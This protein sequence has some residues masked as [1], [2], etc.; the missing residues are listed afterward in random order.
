MRA[1]RTAILLLLATPALGEDVVPF[2]PGTLQFF[3]TKASFAVPAPDGGVWVATKT[4]ITRYTAAGA[5]VTYAINPWNSAPRE[6]AL[7]ADGSIWFST[8]Y[9]IG[10]MSA[11]GVVVEQHSIDDAH[12]L[13]VAADGALWFKRTPGDGIHRLSGGV[14]KDFAEPAHAWSSAPASGSDMWML[15]TGFSG[16]PRSLFRVTA[17]GGVTEFPLSRK[18]LY[19]ELRALPDGTLYASMGVYGSEILHIAPN[20]Q[21]LGRIRT[22]TYHPFGLFVADSEGNIWTGGTGV[23][24]YL[25]RSG[26]IAIVEMPSDPRTCE[27]KLFDNYIPLAVD[28]DGGVWIQVREDTLNQTPGFPVPPCDQP[29]PPP[30]PDLIRVDAQQV[31]AANPP[32]RRRSR[33]SRP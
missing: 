25:D 29:A 15:G 22:A 28:S 32:H 10:R 20:G 7:A 5:G 21:I 2:P 13:T 31:L 27:N 12:H 18:F 24:G 4:G 17:T 23:L 3:D 16:T 11:S 6:L 9:H 26:S 1:V 33:P 8:P 19:G 30:L 14:V